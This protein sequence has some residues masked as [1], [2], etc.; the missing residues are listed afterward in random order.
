M[1]TFIM[2]TCAKSEDRI[3]YKG[4]IYQMTQSKAIYNKNATQLSG[5][6]ISEY[7][8]VILP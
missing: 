4:M 3:K 1:Y 5:I 6:P 7:W 2:H 8:S